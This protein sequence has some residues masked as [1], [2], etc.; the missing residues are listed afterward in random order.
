MGQYVTKGS[1]FVHGNVVVHVSRYYAA[2]SQA[3]EKDLLDSAPPSQQG[4]EPLDKSGTWI[5]EAYVRTEDGP[6][7]T[8][9][10]RATNE[11]LKFAKELEGAVDLRPVNRLALDTAVKVG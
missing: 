6:S 5:V 10:E 7:P 1:R 2:S 3:N 8:L 11:L 9:R 4:L